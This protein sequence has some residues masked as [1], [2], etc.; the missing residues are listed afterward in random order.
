MIKFHTAGG[1]ITGLAFGLM[2]STSWSLAADVGPPG[3]IPAVSGFNGK[4]DGSVGYLEDNDDEG[5]RFQG[6]ATLS[7]PVGCLLGIQLDVG[8]GDLDGDE[9]FG[10]QGHVFIRDPESYLLG[11]TAHY[12]ELSGDDVFRVGPEAELYLDNITISGVATFEMTNGDL[13]DDDLVAGLQASFYATEDFALSAGYRHF[14]DTDAAALGFEYQPTSW[15]GSVYV[16]AM[17]GTDDYLSI[18]GGVRFYFG[19]EEKSLIRRHRE[20]DPSTL[21]LW[22]RKAGE[23]SDECVDDPETIGYNECTGRDTGISG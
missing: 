7:M 12:V 23:E 1:I 21:F 13:N 17:V 14:L 4:L 11:A 18:V 5:M 2:F 15:P 22:L 3:C 8:A 9:Y 20:D 6:V 19:G 16:D 10:V